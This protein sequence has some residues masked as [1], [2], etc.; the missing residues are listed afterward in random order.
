MER[1]YSAFEQYAIDWGWCPQCFG[2]EDKQRMRPHANIR[3]A[4][5]EAFSAIYNEHPEC[6][7]G[8]TTFLHWLPR[9]IE[10]QFFSANIDPSLALQMFRLGMI[11]WPDNDVEPLRQLFCRLALNWWK[12]ADMAPLVLANAQGSQ[13]DDAAIG[14][15]LCEMLCALRINMGSAAT[16]ML[17]INTRAAWWSLLRVF[18]SQ[19]FLEDSVYY[20]VHREEDEAIFRNARA[21][22]DRSARLGVSRSIT[23]E[24][25]VEKWE[26]VHAINSDLADAISDAETFFDVYRFEQSEEDIVADLTTIELARQCRSRH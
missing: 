24:I 13:I 5:P 19:T 21:A 16:A 4:P 26:Q 20:V 7:G 6:S 8:A 2:V 18:R 3:V 22:L 23:R 14:R 10:L 12:R 25:L 11:S 15:R 1:V 9:G 17:E